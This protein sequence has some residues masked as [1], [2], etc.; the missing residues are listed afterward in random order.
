MGGRGDDKVYGGTDPEE[1]AHARRHGRNAAD[2]TIIR[3]ASLGVTRQPVFSPSDQVLP[4][5]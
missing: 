3:R 5:T 4:G 2:L 1:A